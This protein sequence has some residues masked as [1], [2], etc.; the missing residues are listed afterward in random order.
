MFHPTTRRR[1]KLS[2]FVLVGGVV[3]VPVLD[4]ITHHRSE[5]VILLMPVVFGVLLWWG[6][7]R[8]RRRRLRSYVVYVCVMVPVLYAAEALAAE[9]A[10][11]KVLWFEV[12]LAFYFLVA[13]RSAWAVW[14]R[15][16]GRLG[17]SYRR[18]G[19]RA[20]RATGRFANLDVGPRRAVLWT[21]AIRPLRLV[22]AVL[23]F[24]P[25][26]FGSLIH[27]IKIGN[28]V[29]TVLCPDLP[30]EEVSFVTEDG[31]TISGWFLPELGSDSTV[32]ICHGAGA[33]KGNFVGFM[34]LFHGHGYSSLIFDF[35]GHGESD[36][37][38]TTFGLDE[39]LDVAAATEWLASERPA[40]AQ[41]I[42]GLGSSMGA[43]ALVRAAA[44]ELRI[45]ALILDSCFVSA[46]RLAAQHFASVPIVGG[47]LADIALASMSLHAGRSFWQLDAADSLAAIA[48]RPVFLIHGLDDRVI[49]PVNLDLLY[50][51]ATGPKTKWLA[52]GA[53]SNVMSEDFFE[54]QS[55]VQEFLDRVGRQ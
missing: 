5:S 27:R 20:R 47:L 29:A 4:G 34:R 49:P 14:K 33:S 40:Y 51:L 46:P 13:W 52:P 3:A 53:H 10:M 43:M 1:L 16:V 9:M 30:I 26:V 15:S 39:A 32:L 21:R 2:G 31:L 23:V 7:P 48:P 38:T 37:H 42:Y 45:E 6:W 35:R 22:L 17:E 25:L 54:Y 44:D 8:T 24:V 11:G 50:D 36:G 41:H 28:T 55:R 18:W 12:F 19:R